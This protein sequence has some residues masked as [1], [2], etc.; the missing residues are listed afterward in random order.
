MLQ[1]GDVLEGVQRH[2]AVIVVPGQQ[3][4][5]RVLDPVAFWDADVMERGVSAKRSSG[6]VQSS[7][8]SVCR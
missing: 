5:C 1:G 2:H 3:E 7:D 4:H 8:I 6:R